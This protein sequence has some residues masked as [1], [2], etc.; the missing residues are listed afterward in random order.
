MVGPVPLGTDQSVSAQLW[1]NYRTKITN[2]YLR[3]ALIWIFFGKLTSACNPFRFMYCFSHTHG[4]RK[5][6]CF[7]EKHSVRYISLSLHTERYPPSFVQKRH[8][9]VSTEHPSQSSTNPLL[10][11]TKQHPLSLSNSYLSMSNIH[12]HWTIII[13]R[14]TTLIIMEKQ[15]SSS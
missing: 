11:S 7:C 2:N 4:S 12:H 10:S 1:I 15:L 13:L 3:S 6:I 14:L 5:R 8:T 9:P